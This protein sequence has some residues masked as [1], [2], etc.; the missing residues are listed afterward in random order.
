MPQHQGKWVFVLPPE[1]AARQVGEK[2]WKTLAGLL[3]AADRKLFDTKTYLDAFD[4]LLK[5]PADNMVVDLANQALIVQAMDF[6]AT[7]MLVMA[8]SPVTRFTADLLKRRGVRMLHWFIEDYRQAKYWKDV[9]PAYS[10]FLAIQRGPVEKACA[11]AGVRFAYVPTAPILKTRDAV[12]GWRERESTVAFIGFPSRYRIE[13][14][15]TMAREGV[16]L[17]IAGLGWDK[18]RGPLEPSLTGRGWFGPEEAFRLLEGA[19]IGLHLP[20]DDPASGRGDSHVSPRVFDILAAGCLLLSEE[21]P[22]I[23]ETLAGCGFVEFRGP[24]E[25]ARAAK[26][27]L[28][29]AP[30]E[31]VLARNRDIALLEH[32]FARR[33]A[34]IL[35]I[36]CS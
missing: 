1:G 23:R 17:R 28:A 4:R 36:G 27:A 9:L 25:A 22:L 15:E 8:L 20:N 6:G 3:P 13:V 26:A 34:D 5:E 7:H 32:G 16:P 12:K 31:D 19:R 11:E 10:D 24:S 29:E 18:Y 30:A 35:A 33:M 21:A 2:A 14:L